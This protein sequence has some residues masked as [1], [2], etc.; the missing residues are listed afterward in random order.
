M[1]QTGFVGAAEVLE[2]DLPTCDVTQMHMQIICS[3]AYKYSQTLCVL[4]HVFF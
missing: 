3:H 2:K 4:I 1:K